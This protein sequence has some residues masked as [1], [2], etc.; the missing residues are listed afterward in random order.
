MNKKGVQGN[1]NCCKGGLASSFQQQCECKTFFRICLKHYQPNASPE[2]PCTFGGAVTP[3][4]GSN[5]FQ[6]PE[7]IPESSFT[8]PI[9][10]N[11]GFT[12]PVSQKYFPQKFSM[13][14]TCRLFFKVCWLQHRTQTHMTSVLNCVWNL[15]LGYALAL[16][17]LQSDRCYLHLR[18]P[19]VLCSHLYLLRGH[20][21]WSL[22]HC[23]QTSK[24]IFLQVWKK[25]FLERFGYSGPGCWFALLT[26]VN[27]HSHLHLQIIQTV[28]SAQWPLR[29]ILRWE[30]NGLRT[31]TPVEEPN[32]S[33]RTDSCV[34]STTM[35]M[36]AQCSVVPEMMLSATSHVEN[37]AR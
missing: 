28:L 6:V 9:R 19:P 30:R 3:V 22:R 5:S 36:G 35:A 16:S 2:P 34:T 29:G 1:K 37:A 17:R 15:M 7:I 18:W 24:K 27:Y 12:W 10:I 32:W 11:F 20:S 31:C 14:T 13:Q 26:W 23:I 33:T 8:N 4:L 21:R 25:A